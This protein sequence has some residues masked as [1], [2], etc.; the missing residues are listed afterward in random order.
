MLI[1]LDPVFDNENSYS[2]TAATVQIK[3][4]VMKDWLKKNVIIDDETGMR[5]TMSGLEE[6]E[7]KN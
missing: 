2:G 7:G 6:I 5:V 4:A 3:A 1:E